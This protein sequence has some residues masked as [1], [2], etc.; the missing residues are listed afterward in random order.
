MARSLPTAKPINP[1]RQI[2]WSPLLVLPASSPPAATTDLDHVRSSASFLVS[3][4]TDD[5]DDKT[6]LIEGSLPAVCTPIQ[7]IQSSLHRSDLI[8]ASLPPEAPK[9]RT[10]PVSPYPAQAGTP[11][12]AHLVSETRPSGSA[13]EGWEPWVGGWAKWVRGRVLG[14]RDLAGREA[15]AGHLVWK[16]LPSTLKSF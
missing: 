14:Y 5:I 3:P 13:G 11:I 12:R 2:R 8:L 6:T 1:V 16:A 15:E 7:S 4:A 9:V 10:L